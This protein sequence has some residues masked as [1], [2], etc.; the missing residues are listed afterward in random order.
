MMKKVKRFIFFY[1]PA[2]FFFGALFLSISGF[3]EKKTDDDGRDRS[4]VPVKKSKA[5]RTIVIDPGHGGRDGG[6]DGQIT[7]EKTVTLAVALQLKKQI[8]KQLPNIKVVM[9]RTSDVTQD[10]RT[11]AKIA[12]AAN[13]DLFISIHCNSAPTSYSNNS[14]KKSGNSLRSEYLIKGTETYVCSSAKISFKE[15]AMREKSGNGRSK[16][17]SGKN[18][19]VQQARESITQSSWLA[20]EIENEFSKVGRRSRKARERPKGIWVLQAT[21]MPSV[22]IETGFISTPSEEKFLNSTSG[23]KEMAVC[24]TNAIKKYKRRLEGATSKEEKQEN[25]KTRKSEDKSRFP[26][27]AKAL[28]T[29]S[30]DKTS[31]KEPVKKSATAHKEKPVNKHSIAVKTEKESKHT[32]S[33]HKK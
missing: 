10:V 3:R 9:T 23:Q 15:A 11:K 24:I 18:S 7:N 29:A 26:Q 19:Y 28:M 2:A 22:L 17:L 5:L 20:D 32:R 6:A 31:K 33:Q 8:Q 12:N 14:Q 16:N 13:G 27:K 4:E 21:A 1:L 30:K 25:V